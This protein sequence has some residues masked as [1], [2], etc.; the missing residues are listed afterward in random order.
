MDQ[1]DSLS[2]NSFEVDGIKYFKPRDGHIRTHGWGFFSIKFEN[3][4]M[5]TDEDISK[6]EYLDLCP[7]FRCEL[8]TFRLFD[9]RYSTEYWC[10]Q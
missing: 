4:I 5:D 3:W 6:D 10:T 7:P 9:L 2:E 1:F 8:G